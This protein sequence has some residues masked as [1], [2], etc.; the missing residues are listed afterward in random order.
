MNTL[1]HT[2]ALF[3]TVASVAVLLAQGHYVTD[4]AVPRER[5][6]FV[7]RRAMLIAIVT[8]GDEAK[9]NKHIRVFGAPKG[10]TDQKVTPGGQAT[11]TVEPQAL[12]LSKH[13]KVQH[14]SG[15]GRNGRTPPLVQYAITVARARR[16]Y[17]Y[18]CE[19]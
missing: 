10:P 4:C 11:T 12:H 15:C 13:Q 3:R 18:I 7:Q 5:L 14:R 16:K 2:I 6:A 1:R 19:V 9:L 8:E 17:A